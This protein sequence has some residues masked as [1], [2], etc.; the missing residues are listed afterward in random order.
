MTET[1]ATSPTAL[2]VAACRHGSDDPASCFGCAHNTSGW[3]RPSERRPRRRVIVTYSPEFVT[4]ARS[5][6]AR[7][8]PLKAVS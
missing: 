2:C 7:R 4:Q 5:L 1:N 3:P 6:G 8:F